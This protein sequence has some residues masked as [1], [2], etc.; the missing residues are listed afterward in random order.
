MR[1]IRKGY[2]VNQCVEQRYLRMRLSAGE[3]ASRKMR[4]GW[5]QIGNR[6][7]SQFGTQSEQQRTSPEP[8]KSV[9]NDPRRGAGT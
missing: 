7:T 6:V 1:L 8:D 5:M 9:E 3:L 2:F 4:I